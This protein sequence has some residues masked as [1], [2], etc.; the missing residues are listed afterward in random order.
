M[1]L[2]GVALLA[3]MGLAALGLEAWRVLT[4]PAPLRDGPRLVEIPANVS[5]TEIAR[6]LTRAGVI[7]SP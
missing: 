2:R 6:R 1:W 5:V 3:L 7:R 4:P